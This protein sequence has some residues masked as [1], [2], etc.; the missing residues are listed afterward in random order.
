MTFL[1]ISARF[2][3][4]SE[5]I[6]DACCWLCTSDDMLASLITCCLRSCEMTSLRLV[7]NMNTRLET[8]CVSSAIKSSPLSFNQI[9]KE[10]MD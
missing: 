8:G 7:T 9:N 10:I 3:K 2:E 6:K 4:L 1:K 5:L